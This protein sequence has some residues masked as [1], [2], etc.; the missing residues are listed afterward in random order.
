MHF[1]ETLEQYRNA[2][3]PLLYVKTYEEQRLMDALAEIQPKIYWSSTLGWHGAENPKG[4]VAIEAMLSQVSGLPKGM[5]I[6]LK[7]FHGNLGNGTVIRM[8]RD[9]IP[10]L[11]QEGKCIMFTGPV[12]NIP[13][14][15]EK[16]IVLLPFALPTPE[17]LGMILD[18]IVHDTEESSKTTL[19]VSER[20]AVLQAAKS[21]TISEAK[22]GF[23]LALAKEGAFNSE[24]VR[25]VLREKAGMLRKSG[26]LDWI[27]TTSGL[28]NVGGLGNV[29]R[30][31]ETIAPVFWNPDEALKYGLLV[32]DFPRTILLSGVPGCGKSEMA[33]SIPTY[34]KVGCVKTD[35]GRI[36]SQGGSKVGAVEGNIEERNKLVETMEPIVDWWDEAEKGLAG[37][38]GQSTANPWEARMTGSVLTWLEEHRSRVLTVACV[39]KQDQLPPE[40]ISRFQKAFF[41]D[42]PTPVEREEIFQIHCSKRMPFKNFDQDAYVE[43]AEYSEGYNGREIRNA[44]QFCSA[45]SFSAG[46]KGATMTLLKRAIRGIKPLSKTR[47]QDIEAFRLWA[48]EHDIEPASAPVAIEDG[49]RVVNIK[50]GK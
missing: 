32:E 46:S 14:E 13:T 12:V 25:I 36:F 27:E 15:L 48:R 23:A 4:K 16:D 20:Q 22:N 26:L 24:A 30:Y 47:P 31:L 45:A 8:L 1:I 2:R 42:L 37:S 49:K 18:R 9:L 41:V 38:S 50:K 44:I 3:Y 28:N 29:K 19:D 39:N 33:K 10:H 40:M 43:A 21:M 35:F 7:D 5:L 17:Q 11:E 34:L 6:V